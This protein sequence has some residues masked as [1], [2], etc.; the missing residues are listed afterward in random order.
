MASGHALT[1]GETR[2]KCS[3]QVPQ[4]STETPSGLHGRPS[5]VM[6]LIWGTASPTPRAVRGACLSARLWSTSFTPLYPLC[7]FVAHPVCI[8]PHSL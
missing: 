2:A 3:S 6:E 4:Y 7:M 1:E 8:L 5:A